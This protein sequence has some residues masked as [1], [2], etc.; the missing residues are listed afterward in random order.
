M[1]GRGR[2]SISSL[3]ATPTRAAY[4][5]LADGAPLAALQAH[6]TILRAPAGDAHVAHLLA[7]DYADAALLAAMRSTA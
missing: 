4:D 5:A 7:D 6:F 2:S 1:P 3:Q